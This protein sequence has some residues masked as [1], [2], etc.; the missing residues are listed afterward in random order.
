MLSA[1]A[2]DKALAQ[3]RAV[4]T[5]ASAGLQETGDDLGRDPLSASPD[6]VD[7]QLLE[8]DERARGLGRLAPETGLHEA[9]EGV[10]NRLPGTA[11]ST[12]A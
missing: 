11:G 2:A 6:D 4:E 10:V 12:S 7:A 9:W 3:A 1:L 8:S 5:S